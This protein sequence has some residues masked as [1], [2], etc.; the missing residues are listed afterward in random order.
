[1]NDHQIFKPES[2]EEALYVKA[3]RFLYEWALEQLGLE[4]DLIITKEPPDGNEDSAA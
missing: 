3:L 4:A 2:M 1:M